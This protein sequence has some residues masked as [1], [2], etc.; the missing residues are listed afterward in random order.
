VL[1]PGIDTCRKCHGGNRAGSARSGCVECHTYHPPT[2]QRRFQGRR[3]GA[4]GR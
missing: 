3:T 4:G 1:L 2:D